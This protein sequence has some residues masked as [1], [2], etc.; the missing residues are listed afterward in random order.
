MIDRRFALIALAAALVYIGGY[1]WFRQ[2]HV[3]IWSKNGRP[4]VIF[5]KGNL[6]LYYGF[7]PL[8][9]IDGKMTG[10]GFHIGAHH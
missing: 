3:E 1:A 2:T 5:P 7:R 8:S 4:Y 9:F 10:M 6:A